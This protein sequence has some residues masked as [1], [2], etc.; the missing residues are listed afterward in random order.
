MDFSK[1]DLIVNFMCNYWIKAL[2]L[3]GII[4]FSSFLGISLAHPID[5]QKIEEIVISGHKTNGIGNADAASE[6]VVYAIDIEKN[7]SLDPRRY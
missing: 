7:Q 1:I 3:I 2:R 4:F 6:G 5:D